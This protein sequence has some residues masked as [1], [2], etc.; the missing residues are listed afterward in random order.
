M[1]LM[2]IFDPLLNRK[3]FAYTS[4]SIELSLEKRANITLKTVYE[5][6]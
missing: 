6:G 1:N 4:L 2:L 3:F 5:I